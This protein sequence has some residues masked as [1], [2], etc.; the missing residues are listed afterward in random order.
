MNRRQFFQSTMLV[1]SAGVLASPIGAAVAP[2]GNSRPGMIVT[3]EHGKMAAEKGAELL[4]QDGKALDIVERGVNVVEDDPEV[5]SVGYGGLPDESGV[6]TLDACIMDGRGHRGGSVAF[7]QNIK[8]PV[9]V[10]RKVMELTR[11]VLL[12][13]EGALQFARQHGFKEENLLT[14]QARQKWLA[15]RRN[16]SPNDNWLEPSHDTVTMLCLDRN[17]DLAG[18]CSTSGLAWKIH[19]RVGDSPILGAGLYVD[20]QVGAAGATGVGELVLRTLTSF[21]IVEFMR[22]GMR[23]QEACRAALERMVAL[24]P[25][26]RTT[27]ESFIAINKQGEVGCA[28]NTGEFVFYYSDGGPA[29]RTRPTPS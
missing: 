4:R 24:I 7:L 6:V 9:S 16:R 12:A 19:G 20:N 21:T 22:Q 27:Q 3:W 1:G 14:D 15:W 17:G 26:A 18:A 13:G 29:Q 2:S 8:N 10:A 23:P 28:T 5:T 11:H 25:E